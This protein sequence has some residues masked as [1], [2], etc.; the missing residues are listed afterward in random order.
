MSHDLVN[1]TSED[2]EYYTP[3]EILSLVREVMGEIDLDP[4]SCAIANETVQADMFF[5]KE[6]DG[7]S[8]PW[9]G[10]V[11]M[12]HPFHKGEKACAKKCKKKKCDP[13][14]AKGR[15][16]CIT[17]D[18][19]SNLEWINKLDSEYKCGNVTEALCITFSSMSEGWMWPLLHQLQCFPKGRIHYRKPDGTVDGSATK[20]SVITYFGPNKEKFREVFGRIGVVK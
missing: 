1:Q 10:K 5:T 12:N 14:N 2:F 13:K 20:G 7:L 9:K 3:S 8:K 6:D 16:H 18:I 15:G 4:A 17:E 19:P 11:W